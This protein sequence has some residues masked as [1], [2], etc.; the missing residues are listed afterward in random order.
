M[1]ERPTVVIDGAH[2]GEGILALVEALKSYRGRKIKLLFA[3]MS[4]KD[5]RL[6]LTRLI[7]VVSEAVFT[8]VAMERSADPAELANGFAG[9]IATR[10][11]P[12]SRAALRLLIDESA[13]D[14][15][16]VVAGSLYLLGEI[17]PMLQE[18]AAAQPKLAG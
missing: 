15:V 11:H 2:N 1:L 13:P 16:I 9:R 14:D 3:A 6:M 7:G 12:D 17:R 8:R 5:W 10:A 18:I 4:D